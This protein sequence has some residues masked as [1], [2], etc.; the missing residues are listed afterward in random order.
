MADEGS[1][2]EQLVRIGGSVIAPATLLSALLFYFG[3]VSSRAQYDYFGVDVDTIGLSTQ[4]YV[5]RSPQS[6]LVPLLA[7]L[8]IGAVA[9]AVHLPVRRRALANPEYR[10]VVRKGVAVGIAVM[11]IGI[12][13]LFLYFLIGSWTY[14]HLV[15]PT[16]IAVGG[17]L[18][19]YALMTLRLI[20]SKTDT[21]SV[22]KFGRRGV[23]VLIWLTVAACVF[24]STAT[25]AQWSGRGRAHEQARD[26]TIFPSVIVDTKEPLSLLPGTVVHEITLN[27]ADKGDTFRYRYWNLRLLIEGHDRM[28]L[29][30]NEWS[31]HGTTLM[32]PLDGDVRVQFQFRNIAP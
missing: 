12:V 11:A 19:A 27:S 7:S 32:V 29:V 18:T 20:D 13:L 15:T 16:V 14:Y 17:S 4:D 28:F 22:P 5:M 30:P 10:S 9:M 25:V 2:F 1:R 21:Q 6:L 24:W 23:I 31:P 3:Y 8:V 26:L